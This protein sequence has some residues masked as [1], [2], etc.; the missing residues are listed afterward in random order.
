MKTD[1]LTNGA[2]SRLF[3][4]NANTLDSG[5]YTCALAD[6]ASTYVYVHVLNGK[7]MIKHFIIVYM[8][9]YRVS[10]LVFH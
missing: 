8:F 1:I 4:A 2:K 3:I 9:L 6:I 7:S 5:N 10:S